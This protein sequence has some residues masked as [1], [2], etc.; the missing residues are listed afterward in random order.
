MMKNPPRK[1]P[2]A[3]VAPDA[4]VVARPGGGCVLRI[5]VQPG[6]RRDAIVGLHDG[7]LKVAINAP[8]L[9][10][11][12]NARCLRFLAKEVLGIPTRDLSLVQGERRR[13]KSIAISSLSADDVRRR[14]EHVLPRSTR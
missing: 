7:A 3:D 5:Y 12:A 9:E 14:I 11:K 1:T 10:G 6:A 13:Q 2:A 4:F 8:P